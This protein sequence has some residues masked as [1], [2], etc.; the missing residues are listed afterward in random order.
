[1][2]T[3]SFLLA[4]RQPVDECRIARLDLFAGRCSNTSLNQLRDEI[5]SHG[6]I[7][8]VRG[9]DSYDSL[10]NKTLGMLKY[11]LASRKQYTHIL[12]TDDDVYVRVHRV[13]SSLLDK[14]KQPKMEGVYMGCVEN[15][16]GF[17][18]IRDPKSK[19]YF[20]YDYFSRELA[21]EING[22]LYAAGFGYVLSRD[23]ALHVMEKVYRWEKGLAAPPG[24]HGKLKML[25]DVMIGVMLA[26]KVDGPQNSYRFKSSWMPCDPSTAVIP[27]ILRAF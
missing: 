5:S 7:A 10:T 3:S 14:S 12:K 25:E 6:D 27:L 15:H 20:S 23:L 9:D 2:S 8:V 4:S 17:N 21:K 18:V 22:T 11:A 26:D 1:M 24:W 16:V 13:F 19:W